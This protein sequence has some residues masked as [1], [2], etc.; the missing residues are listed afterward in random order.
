VIEQN[1]TTVRSTATSY[2]PIAGSLYAT[3]TEFSSYYI[4]NLNT[5]TKQTYTSLSAYRWSLDVL[6][7][8]AKR[9]TVQ[10]WAASMVMY[11]LRNR[12]PAPQPEPSAPIAF[13]VR[14]IQTSV[15]AAQEPRMATN[16]IR[17]AAT[18][19]GEI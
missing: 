3:G 6:Q 9:I 19:R 10:W 12:K 11:T 17:I 16:V 2:F 14:L 4:A 13:P 18:T 8:A 5:G 1:H 15:A 7:S